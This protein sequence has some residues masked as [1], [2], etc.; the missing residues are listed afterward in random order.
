MFTGFCG[1]LRKRCQNVRNYAGCIGFKVEIRRKN[2]R[3]NEPNEQILPE[4]ALHAVTSKT[5]FS[6]NG[7]SIAAKVHN[8]M[9]EEFEEDY[10][11]DLDRE[12]I[13][14]GL[15]ELGMQEPEAMA[16]LAALC[17]RFLAFEEVEEAGEDEMTRLGGIP[18]VPADF[19]WPTHNGTPL[20]F[21]GQ[22]DF[23]E[24]GKVLSFFYESSSQP[25]GYSPEDKNAA[26]VFM[27]DRDS[28]VQARLP[29]ELSEVQRFPNTFRALQADVMLPD[30][31]S[32]IFHFMEDV[33]KSD[34]EL[35]KRLEDEQE[36]ETASA[37]HLLGYPSILQGDMELQCEMASNGYACGEPEAFD[38]PKAAEFEITAGEWTLLAQFDS[39][40][41]LGWN[42]QDGGRL[43]F[44]IKVDDLTNE[45][46]ENTWTILQTN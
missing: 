10:E 37:H 12:A 5:R 15:G 44:W 40:P 26:R 21:L 25:W 8:Q 41:E 19:S 32:D 17:H 7:T 9:N 35:L 23:F 24:D 27:F 38:S 30:A 45:R 6:A 36:E 22:A 4:A 43:F 46:F 33:P 34:V 28:L 29:E 2:R 16:E 14:E 1:D 18:D 20:A 3:L 42:W 31:K 39:D 13:A 11:D